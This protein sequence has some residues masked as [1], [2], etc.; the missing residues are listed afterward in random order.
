MEEFRRMANKLDKAITEALLLNNYGIRPCIK[1]CGLCKYH[2]SH[3]NCINHCWCEVQ[4][5]PKSEH[6]ICDC[7][8]FENRWGGEK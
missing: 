2:V 7:R 6:E 1:A 3:G 4:D 8:K 5:I